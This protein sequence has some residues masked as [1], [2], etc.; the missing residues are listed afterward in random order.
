MTPR[1]LRACVPVVA[2]LVAAG[3]GVGGPLAADPYGYGVDAGGAYGGDLGGYY[4]AGASGD[5]SY[6]GG[7]G[8]DAGYGGGYGGASSYDPGD[9][10]YGMAYGG[11]PGALAPGGLGASPGPATS[12]TYGEF[13]AAYGDDAVL[14]ARASAAP[15]PPPAPPTTLSAWVVEVKEPG[16]LARLRGA[17]ITARVEVENPSGRTLAGRVRV[18]FLDDGNPTGV[19]QTRRVTLAPGETQVLTF[20]VEAG[21]LDDAEASV[22]TL[23]T[24]VGAGLVLDR[25]GPGT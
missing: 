1:S 7:Y 21:R 9:T 3:C 20:T 12:G 18:R 8:E 2:A 14:R 22:E 23:G 13:G 15:T 5:L 25:P 11:S 19:L 24:P 16:F 4:G 10:S 6:G 17:R